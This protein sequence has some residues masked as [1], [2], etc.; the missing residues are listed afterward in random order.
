MTR[1]A[2]DARPAAF[3][4]KTGIGYYTWHLLRRLPQVDPSSTY[5]A[6]YLNARAVLGRKRHPFDGSEFPSNLSARSTPFPA[7]WFERLSERFE[8]PRVEWFVRF[9]VLF[10]PNFVPPPTRKGR[11][12]L[13]VHDLGFRL[14]PETAPHSTRRWLARLDRALRQASRVIAVS[15]ATRRDLIDLYSV[16][17]DRLAVV[18]HGVDHETFRPPPPEAVAAVRSRF[19]IDGPYLL[20]L[21]GI[22]PRKNLPRLLEAFARLSPDLAVCLVL[23]GGRA[24]WNPEGWDLLRSAIDALPPEVRRRVIST[25]Y[26]TEEQKVALLGGAEALVYP[27]LYEGFGLPVLEAMA[28][29]TPVL[30]SNLSAL[31]EVAGDAGLLVDPANT[32]ALVEGIERLLRDD[33]LRSRLKAAGIERAAGFDWTETARLTAGVLHQA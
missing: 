25:S 3:P 33:D 4:E 28:C 26:V 9:D 10:A 22:E 30:T 19:A 16:P 15:E 1:I 13:T 5:L 2:V 29:G 27:S 23:A 31:P 6:W 12:V 7:Q 24:A 11:L 14:F 18:P 20:S 17:E 32:D 8:L 21:G